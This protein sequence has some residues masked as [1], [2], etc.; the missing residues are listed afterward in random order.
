MSAP[1]MPLAWNDV[2]K[3]CHPER[4][5]AKSEAI[6]QT[7]SKDPCCIVATESSERYFRTVVRFFTEHDPEQ[8]PVSGY[9]TAACES[10]DWKCRVEEQMENESR[11]DVTLAACTTKQ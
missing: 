8:C 5:L 4:S 10:P 7:K 1:S 11:R 3:P 6:R 2:L 9:E